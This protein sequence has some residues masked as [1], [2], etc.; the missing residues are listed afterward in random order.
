MAAGPLLGPQLQVSAGSNS[1]LYA[2]L[3]W[4]G[5]GAGRVSE[6]QGGCPQTCHRAGSLVASCA[7]LLRFVMA[8]CYLTLTSV[9]TCSPSSPAARGRSC[10]RCM[11]SCWRRSVR[12]AAA[13]PA[14]AGERGAG[15]RH[16]AALVCCVT[17]VARVVTVSQVVV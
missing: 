10:T 4:A 17:A 1:H 13:A 7:S 6:E 9:C 3:E 2:K 8:H 11:L 12:G 14:A 5:Q 15:P 16:L